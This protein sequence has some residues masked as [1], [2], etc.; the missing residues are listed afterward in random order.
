MNTKVT[1]DQSWENNRVTKEKSTGKVSLFVKY[2][3]H[4]F[5]L[6]EKPNKMKITKDVKRVKEG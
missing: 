2:S 6:E 1:A 4:A 3:F 5:L